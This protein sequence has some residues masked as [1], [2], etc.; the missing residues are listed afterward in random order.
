M[1]NVMVEDSSTGTGVLGDE[2]GRNDGAK[3]VGVEIGESVGLSVTEIV[4][5]PN[6]ATRNAVIFPN[7]S[8]KYKMFPS[9]ERL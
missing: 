1:G 8:P 2:V 6:D 9:G 7:I 4:G 3:V 5:E